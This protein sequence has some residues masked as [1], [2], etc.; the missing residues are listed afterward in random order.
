MEHLQFIV[1]CPRDYGRR[2]KMEIIFSEINGRPFPFP[3]NGC[4]WMN[5]DPACLQ[6]VT[7]LDSMFRRNPDLN[8]ENPITPAC[9]E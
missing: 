6:C 8:P 1:N 3:C 2:Y 5:G 4:D 9:P 7:N